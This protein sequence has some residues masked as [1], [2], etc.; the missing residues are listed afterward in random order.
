MS[1]AFSTS[2]SSAPRPAPPSS[3]LPAASFLALHELQL[4]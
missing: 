3:S 4:F 2:S 1:A